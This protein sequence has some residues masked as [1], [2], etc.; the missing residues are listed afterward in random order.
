MRPDTPIALALRLTFQYLRYLLQPVTV[1]RAFH[2]N[3]PA[4]S[5]KRENFL[6]CW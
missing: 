3:A 1:T 2:E 4:T 6:I 5:L